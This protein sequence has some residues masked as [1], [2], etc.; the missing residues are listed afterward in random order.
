MEVLFNMGEINK[1]DEFG[2]A[3]IKSIAEYNLNKILEIGSW[4]GTGSTACLIE[5]MLKLQCEKKLVCLEVNSDRYLQL[6]NNTKEHKWIECYNTTSI[7]YSQLHEKEFDKI[8]DSPFNGLKKHTTPPTKEQAKL[9]FEED[10]KNL[11]NTNAGFLET[12]SSF[13]DAV[14]IDGGEFFGYSEYKIIKDRT[15]VLFLDDYYYAYKTNQIARELN[16]DEEWEVI[17]GNKNLRSGYAI[18]KRKVFLN[19]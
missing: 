19:K 11:K 2:S 6:V 18:F 12:D 9:W 15:N 16:Q 17:A 8:W 10:V 7:S 14:L 1:T 4:D 5:G 13:Y 3:L